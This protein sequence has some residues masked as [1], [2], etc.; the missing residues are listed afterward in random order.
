MVVIAD[1][2][3]IRN[4]IIETENG[5]SP[6]PLG[7]D[8]ATNRT[9]GNKEFLMNVISYLTD[10]TDLMQLRAREIKLRMLNK[11]KLAKERLKWQ[12]VNLVLP[13]LLVILIGIL[14]NIYRKRFYTR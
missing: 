4:D 7:F 3:I 9:F 8:R 12:I 1:A 5:P 11:T 6:L 10:D 13:V 14:Y 2:D